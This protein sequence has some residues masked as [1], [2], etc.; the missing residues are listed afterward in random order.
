ME[1]ASMSTTEIAG[2][3]LTFNK[4]GHLASFGDWD[5]EIAEALAADEGLTL[6]ECHWKVID[7][8]RAYYETHEMPPSPRVIIRSIGENLSAHVPCTR[9]HLEALFPNG[10][11]KQACRVA[12]LPRAY[13]QSC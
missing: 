1:D 5:P 7:F 4:A 10:G 12:G 11:C 9:K 2:R 3:E 8:L 6:T 13:C